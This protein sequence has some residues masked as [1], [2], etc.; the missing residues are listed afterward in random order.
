MDIRHTKNIRLWD[1]FH[2]LVISK[3]AYLCGGSILSPDIYSDRYQRFLQRLRQAR[4][5]T[6]FSKHIMTGVL[7]NSVR[8][9]GRLRRTDREKCTGYS[10]RFVPS[11]SIE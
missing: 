2:L 3:L 5:D 6:G 7:E 8:V 9:V 4:K 1:I 11:S 10:L